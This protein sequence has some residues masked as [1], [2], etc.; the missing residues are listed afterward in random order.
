MKNRI[1]IEGYIDARFKKVK[2][3]FIDNFIEYDEVGAACTIYYRG[4][5]VVDLWGGFKNDETKEEWDKDTLLLVFSATKGFAALTLAVAHSRGYIDFDE[6]VSTYW[7][8]FGQNGKEDITVR[9]LLDHQAGLCT[10]ERLPIRSPLDLDTIEIN[11]HL[12][13]KTPEWQPGDYSGYHCWTLGWYIGELIRRVDPKKRKLGTFFQE[14]IATP[15]EIEIYIG[16]PDSVPSKRI[17]KLK[18]IDTIPKAIPHIFEAPFKLETQ[19]LWKYSITHKAI[20][21]EDRE[22][23]QE[24][25]NRRVFQKIELPS[26]N[27]IGQVRDMAK[28]YAHILEGGK[29]IGLNRSTLQELMG[30]AQKPRKGFKDKVLQ[31]EVKYRLGFWKPNPTCQFGRSEKAFGH[32]GVGG[33]FCFADPDAEIAYTYAPNKLDLRICN[34]KRERRIRE[35]LYTCI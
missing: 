30:P 28:L 26:A 8:E 19:Y 16:L 9:Q 20:M 10:L 35:A 2:E 32:P 29:E 7:P 23:T 14:E 11:E 18:G 4:Q 17:A 24:Q 13:K 34:D 33:A 15:L 1:P 3:A 6:R 25:F 31:T 22:L 5:K 27:G 12:A 21:D